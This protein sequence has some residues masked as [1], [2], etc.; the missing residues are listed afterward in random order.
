MKWKV[1]RSALSG[2]IA[3]PPSKSHTIRALVV[4]TLAEGLSTI[5]EPLMSGDGKSALAA[6]AAMGATVDHDDNVITIRGT[7]GGHDGGEETVYLANSGTSMRLFAS[8]AALGDRPRTFDGDASLRSRP[9][10]PLLGALEELG[11]STGILSQTGDVPFT[12]HGPIRGGATRVAGGTSQFLSSLLLVAP[13]LEGDT[14]IVVDRLNERPYVEITLWWL[15]KMGIR[16]AVSDDFTTFTVAGGQAYDAIDQRIPGDFSS[17]TF[18]AVAAAAGTGL[19]LENLDFSDPQGDK[20]VFDML[21]RMGAVVERRGL[22]VNVR[23]GERLEG[24]TIDLNGMPDALPALAV[25]GCRARGTTSIVNVPQARI[26]ECDRIAVMAAE[27][28]KMGARVTELEDGLVVE[29]S[30]LR[31]APV[32]GHD[33]HRVVMA[34]ALAGMAAEGETV[35]DTA[36]AATVTY[37]TFVRDF[38]A[39]GAKLEE[40]L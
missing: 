23:A 9:M 18:A 36:E 11:A 13:L 5:R 35:I 38:Q 7:G 34:L 10:R 26:K 2:T 39:L 1:R 29:Q 31:G 12:I 19:T 28:A 20:A 32:H 24:T 25:L 8:V 30:T 6:A 3:I 22:S 40:V 16:Y 21:E 33:D 15:D 27:L 14:T 17:A 37:P 4:A